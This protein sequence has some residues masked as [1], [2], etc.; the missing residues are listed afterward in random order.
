MTLE[1]EI[2]TKLKEY[3][4]AF[5]DRRGVICYEDFKDLASDIATILRSRQKVIAEGKISREFDSG[6]YF[7]FIGSQETCNEILDI[8]YRLDEAVTEYAYKNEGKQVILSLE[9]KE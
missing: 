5:D 8:A 1:E 3:G 2:Y 9:V 4:S 6:H 7:T